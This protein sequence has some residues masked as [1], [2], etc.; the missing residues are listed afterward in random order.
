[1][2]QIASAYTLYASE[3]QFRDL[4]GVNTL[5]LRLDQG[6]VKYTVG[7]PK[8][9]EAMERGGHLKGQAPVKVVTG[10]G[11]CKGSISVVVDQI[12]GTGGNTKPSD[13]AHMDYA[14][15]AGLKSTLLGGAWGFEI[16]VHHFSA[17][18]AETVIFRYCE[19][20]DINVDPKGADGIMS[21]SFDFEDIETT[22]LVM[23]GRQL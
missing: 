9:A 3:V 13:W 17:G 2:T 18:A 23:Q 16:R 6:A 14:R 15:V 1:M 19:P 20:G 4:G 10:D 5:L 21:L 12:I 11:T 22:P 7:A 8:T